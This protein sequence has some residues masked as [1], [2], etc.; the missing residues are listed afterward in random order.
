MGANGLVNN[1]AVQ[2]TGLEFDFTKNDEQPY[3]RTIEVSPAPLPAALP[4]T[5]LY[6][7]SSERSPAL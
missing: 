5:E 7:P 2:T 1:I 4:L 6:H 3:I